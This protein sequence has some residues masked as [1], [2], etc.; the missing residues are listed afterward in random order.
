M[1]DF[2][3]KRPTGS[4]ELRIRSSDRNFRWSEFIEKMHEFETFA[5]TFEE[6]NHT[7]IVCG[8]SPERNVL[9]STIMLDSKVPSRSQYLPDKL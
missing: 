8:L 2:N 9:D 1:F 7:D 6:L 3:S 5:S 4:D